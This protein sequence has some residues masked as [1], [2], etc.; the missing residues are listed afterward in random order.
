MQ[1]KPPFSKNKFLTFNIVI[2]SNIKN[3]NLA[4]MISGNMITIQNHTAQE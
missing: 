4:T 1:L 2:M 3:V